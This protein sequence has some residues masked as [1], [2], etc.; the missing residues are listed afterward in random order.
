M[1]RI[2]ILLFS[3]SLS[4][5]VLS[6]CESGM[7]SSKK[8]IDGRTLHSG[9][10][11][12]MTAKVGEVI[13]LGLPGNAGTGFTWSIAG[14]LPGCVKKVAEPYFKADHPELP[15]SSGTTRFRFEAVEAG[16][17]SIRFEYAR[18]WEKD[19]RPARWSVVEITVGG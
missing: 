7:G 1:N 8:A 10:T 14:D 17:G 3:L 15:G 16:S 5:I 19:A 9:S 11:T 6:G 13:E 2:T 18:P 12:Q 4:C